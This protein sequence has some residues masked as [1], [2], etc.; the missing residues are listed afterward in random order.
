[1]CLDDRRRK[2]I[3]GDTKGHVQVLNY[4]NGA[5]LRTLEPHTAEVSGMLYAAGKSV[6]TFSWDSKVN[7]HDEF[8]SHTKSS[9]IRSVHWYVHFFQCLEWC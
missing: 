2:I 4:A 7:I 9:V 8:G 6:I 1:M 3:I 5:L